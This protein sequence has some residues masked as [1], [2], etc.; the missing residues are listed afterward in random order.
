MVLNSSQFG[1]FTVNNFI[2]KT[3]RAF[4]E[5]L[6]VYTSWEVEKDWETEFVMT[7]LWKKKITLQ[8]VVTEFG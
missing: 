2:I 8:V 4:E 3:K 1:R 5:M 6:F 7:N